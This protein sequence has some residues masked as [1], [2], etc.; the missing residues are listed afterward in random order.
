[1]TC[2]TGGRRG[3][4]PPPPQRPLRP[5]HHFARSGPRKVPH[6]CQVRRLLGLRGCAALENRVRPPGLV[7]SH[8]T[9]RSDVSSPAERGVAAHPA[10]GHGRHSRLCPAPSPG[11]RRPLHVCLA[12]SSLCPRRRQHVKTHSALRWSA[13]WEQH[14]ICFLTSL[15]ENCQIEIIEN[16][17]DLATGC[18]IVIVLEGR[19]GRSGEGRFNGAGVEVEAIPRA[20]HPALALRQP[21]TPEEAKLDQ[22]TSRSPRLLTLRSVQ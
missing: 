17:P 19:S 10:A 1:M 13:F 9:P 14:L 4:S 2:S 15:I 20:D 22:F 7:C 8:A 12:L 18:V 11:S 16:A 6:L 5:A 3:P 21:P